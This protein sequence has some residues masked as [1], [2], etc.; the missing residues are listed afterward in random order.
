MF[1]I[2]SIKSFYFS[3]PL[4]LLKSI[5]LLSNY[6]LWITELSLAF[7]L[8]FSFFLFQPLSRDI[9]TLNCKTMQISIQTVP[10]CHWSSTW[11]ANL[12]CFGSPQYQSFQ[13]TLHLPQAKGWDVCVTLFF[14]FLKEQ[15]FLLF[16]TQCLKTTE[17]YILSSFTEVKGSRVS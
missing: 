14:S 7:Y 1:N 15:R 2:I 3:L 16:F 11:S 10:S 13:I 8:D 9:V 6:F 4:F 17:P 12:S 5:F